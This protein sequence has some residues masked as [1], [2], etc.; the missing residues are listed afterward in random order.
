MRRSNKKF[1]GGGGGGGGGS[2][3]NSQMHG[4]DSV[5][6]KQAMPFQNLTYAF[7]RRLI[8]SFVFSA[9]RRLVPTTHVFIPVSVYKVCRK[10]Y[11]FKKCNISRIKLI[12]VHTL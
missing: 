6:T 2:K 1:S 3:L 4:R 5:N 12:Q 10:S 8:T 9:N 7:A 11:L